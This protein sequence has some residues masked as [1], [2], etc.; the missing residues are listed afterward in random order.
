LHIVLPGYG[1]N[2][3]LSIALRRARFMLNVSKHVIGVSHRLP[4]REPFIAEHLTVLRALAA[5]DVAD[6]A[7]ALREHIAVSLSKVIRRVG[8]LRESHRPETPAYASPAGRG[9]AS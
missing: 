7:E 9:G 6:A 2:R 3:E 5:G 4:A 8:E 1:P